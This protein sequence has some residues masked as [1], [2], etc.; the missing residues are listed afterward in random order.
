MR[1]DVYDVDVRKVLTQMVKRLSPY[2]EEYKE[3]IKNN[4]DDN[5]TKDIPFGRLY[6]TLL[7]KHVGENIVS[8]ILH[9]DGIGLTRS[10]RLKMWLFSGALVELPSILRYRRHN[11]VLLSIWVAYVEPDPDLWLRPIITKLNYV[12]ARGIYLASK[13]RSK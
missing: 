5:D 2:I 6:R 12:K 9:L 11:M 10:T 8:L 3:K 7:E 4:I 1:A 13:K